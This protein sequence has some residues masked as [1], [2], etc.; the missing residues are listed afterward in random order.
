MVAP[1]NADANHLAQSKIDLIEKHSGE[2]SE[3]G[4]WSPDTPAA[5]RTQIDR[6]QKGLVMASINAAA[7]HP[8]QSLNNLIEKHSSEFSVSPYYLGGG[9]A[10]SVVTS[11]LRFDIV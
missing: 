4:T 11:S 3:N 5:K 7:E 10:I 6:H 8:T 9:D 2:F 1:N